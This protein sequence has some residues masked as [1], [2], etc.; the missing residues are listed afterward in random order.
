MSE[1]TTTAPKVLFEIT[2]DKLNTGLRGFPV[3]TCRT[4]A[5]SPTL[6]VTYVGYTLEQLKDKSAE[7]V[8]YLLLHKELPTPEQ[9][10]AFKADLAKRSEIDPAVYDALKAL[11]KSGHPM[12]WLIT[13]LSLLGMTGKSES[14][15]YKEDC[16]NLIA[17]ISTLVAAIIRIREGWG[18]P[19]QPRFDLPFAE[20][21]AHMIGLEEGGDVLADLLRMFYILHMDHGGGNLSTFTGKAVASGKADMYSSIAAAMAALYGPRHGR[22]NQEC[23]AFVKEVGT[24]DPV[25]C[26]KRVRD[27]MAAGGLVYG[28]GHAV[29]RQEDPRATI[30]YAWG[31]KHFPDNELVKTAITLRNV[32]PPILQ[33]N[34]KISNPFPNVDAVSGSLLTA[35]GL[36][37][38]DYYTLMFG[39]SRVAGIAAQIVD[40]RPFPGK[41]DGLAIYRPK[42]IADGQPASRD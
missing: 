3:G 38:P 8:I 33:E 25:E 5:V 30:Q 10:E 11:P 23:L 6:G 29:L 16:L 2:E 4:S 27:I 14:N 24:S 13:G 36:S 31:E 9:T 20:N 22:A 41:K 21:F 32:V 18:D 26:E 7:E 12:E 19:I 42:Y 15:D 17:R 39:W 28:F 37:N 35:A 34:P 40:E 1:A